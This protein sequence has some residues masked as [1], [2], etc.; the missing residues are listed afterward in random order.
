M[1][2]VEIIFNH[3]NLIKFWNPF[4]LKFYKS[5][6]YCQIKEFKSNQKNAT[7][8]IFNNS[9][10]FIRKVIKIVGKVI[11]TLERLSKITERYKKLQKGC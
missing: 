8:K 9:S 7:E 11:K 4:V 10:I 6:K 2:I 3:T 5:L 1:Q